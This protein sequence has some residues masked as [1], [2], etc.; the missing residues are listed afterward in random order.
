MDFLEIGNELTT[1]AYKAALRFQTGAFK[2]R[3]E[4]ACPCN[5]DHVPYCEAGTLGVK[6]EWW[7]HSSSLYISYTETGLEVVSPCKLNLFFVCEAGATVGQRAL[8]EI[9]DE[10]VVN[11]QK[12]EDERESVQSP[13]ADAVAASVEK[14][15]PPVIQV[16]FA[17]FGGSTLLDREE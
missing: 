6:P 13:L 9:Y 14:G 4:K 5:K 8:D 11:L 15:F 12:E 16:A 3:L 7:R 10:L 17:C 2:L 1:T